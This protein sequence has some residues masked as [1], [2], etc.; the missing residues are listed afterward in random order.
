MKFRNI[1]SLFFVFGLSLVFLMGFFLGTDDNNEIIKDNILNAEKIV[2]LKFNDVKRD[3]MLDELKDN[4]KNYNK[5]RELE[6]PNSLMPAL[7]FN[8]IPKN[9]K[10]ESKQLPVKFETPK[11]VIVPSNLEDAAFYSISELAYLIKNR[12]ITSTELTKMYLGRLKKYGPI[13]ECVVTLT[14]D[15]A[16]RQAKRADEEIA[17]GKYRG[18][19]HGI[20][21]GIKDLFATKNYKTTW[22][23]PPYKEQLI[24]EDAEVV[25]RLEKAG[26][27]LIAKLS[28]GELAWGETWFGGYTRNPWNLEQGSSGSSAGSAAA[29]AAGLV[30]FA[31]GTETWGSIISPSTRCGV[32]GLRPTYGR[33]SR[34]GAMA[35]SWSMDK[36][37]PICRSAEDCAIVFNVIYGS[38][39]VDPTLYDVPFNYSSNVDLK[40]IRI[41]F[42]KSEFDL[43]RE[44]K[45]NDD[46]VLEKLKSLSANLISIELPNL[47][48]PEMSFILSTEAAAAFDDLTRS[49]KDDMLVRQIKNSWPNVLR[50]HRFVPAVEYIQANRVR[51]ILIQEMQKLFDKIDVYIVP[52]FGG[53]SLLLTNL[54]GHPSVV[55]PNGFN[56]KGSPTSITIV[57]KLFGEGQLLAVAKKFQDG[58]NFHKNYPGLK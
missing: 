16:L 17:S 26:A 51:N 25:K 45:E 50:A 34:V 7:L 55:V 48:V 3:S 36:I 21:Y 12:K 1:H 46:A 13:L 20:P 40:K 53:N 27:V 19:L 35:L 58:T 57:G 6:L 15:L 42:I 28:M 4:L 30:A 44:S 9:F 39:G 56:E 14:E 31:I 10:F 43:Q 49:G 23:A 22:G 8:P 38:D 2:G 32:T 37:G 24:D 18:P 41:G 47:P 11:K 5:L 29:T 33:V 52:T 54:T